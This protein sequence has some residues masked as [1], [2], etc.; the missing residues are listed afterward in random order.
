MARVIDRITEKRI[1]NLLTNSTNLHAIMQL[2]LFESKH[3]LAN[4]TGGKHGS[5]RL[6]HEVQD[7]KG[8]ERNRRSNHEKWPQSDERQMLSLRHRDVQDPR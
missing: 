1:K 4:Y 8:N 6:L 2:D 3:D 5:N 7:K